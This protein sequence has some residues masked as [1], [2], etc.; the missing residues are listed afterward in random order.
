MGY[1]KI[2]MNNLS[3]IKYLLDPSSPYGDKQFYNENS[4]LYLDI[5]NKVLRIKKRKKRVK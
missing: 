1:K 5:S 4:D 2:K 3:N